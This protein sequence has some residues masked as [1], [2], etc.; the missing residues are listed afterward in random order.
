MDS[1][2]FKYFNSLSPSGPPALCRNGSET[3]VKLRH[4]SVTSFDSAI[5]AMQC[6]SECFLVKFMI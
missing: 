4:N 6:T 5:T 2:I 3:P 1:T